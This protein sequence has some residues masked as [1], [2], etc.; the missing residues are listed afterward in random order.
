MKYLSDAD[1]RFLGKA[2]GIKIKEQHHRMFLNIVLK[3]KVREAVR[4]ICA[5]EIG[6]GLQP[7]KLAED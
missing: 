5:W 7:D 2:R 6:G 3:V 4:F 1:T